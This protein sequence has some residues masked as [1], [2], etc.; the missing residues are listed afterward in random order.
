VRE[1]HRG[2]RGARGLDRGGDRGGA[3]LGVIQ[4]SRIWVGAVGDRF[5]V[6]AIAWG[7]PASRCSVAPVLASPS[8]VGIRLPLTGKIPPVDASGLPST[9]SRA[10]NPVGPPVATASACTFSS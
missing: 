1:H 5:T 9:A 6:T 3:A 10:E 2:R 7:T 4:A 8:A